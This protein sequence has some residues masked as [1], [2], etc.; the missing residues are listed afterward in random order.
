[1]TA[2]SARN[3]DGEALQVLRY[4]P[5]SVLA[6][7]AAPVAVNA[8]A[9]IVMLTATVDVWFCLGAAASVAGNGCDFLPASYK[10]HEDVPVGTSISF[11]SADGSAG[12]VSVRPSAS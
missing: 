11:V 7:S 3:Q 10:H 5:S 4:A 9:A 8:S 6:V 2:T 12:F 1:M